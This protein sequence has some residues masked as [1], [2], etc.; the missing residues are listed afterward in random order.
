M[1]QL[2][3]MPSA[4]TLQPATTF[5]RPMYQDRLVTT[6]SPSVTVGDL[7]GCRP[8]PSTALPGVSLRC[9]GRPRL[10]ASALLVA[11]ALGAAGCSDK[12]KGK[13]PTAA[14]LVSAGLAAVQQG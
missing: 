10:L 6:P 9:L 4:G 8:K 14:Q 2:D 11:L 1:S 3:G 13:D 5:A 7:A 12:P